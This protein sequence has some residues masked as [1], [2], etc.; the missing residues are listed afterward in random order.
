MRAVEL[1]MVMNEESRV[2]EGVAMEDAWLK[3]QCDRDR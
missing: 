3:P 1:R 2:N